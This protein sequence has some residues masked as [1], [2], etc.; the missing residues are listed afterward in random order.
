[1]LLPQDG[2]HRL[3]KVLSAL[4]RAEGDRTMN[5]NVFFFLLWRDIISEKNALNCSKMKPTVSSPTAQ[6]KY[7]FWPSLRF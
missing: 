1:M 5:Y 4:W 3:Q 2:M 7:P 6:L